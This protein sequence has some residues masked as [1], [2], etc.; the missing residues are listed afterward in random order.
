MA[1]GTVIALGNAVFVGI[2]GVSV[3]GLQEAVHESVLFLPSLWG[4]E[5]VLP[6][7]LGLSPPW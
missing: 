1:E 4:R 6:Q 7:S 2:F 3:M 5:T